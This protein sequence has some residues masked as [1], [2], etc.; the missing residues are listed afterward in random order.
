MLAAIAAAE[1]ALGEPADPIL[2]LSALVMA[3][4]GERD[5]IA[6]RWRLSTAERDGLTVVDRRLAAT[7]AGLDEAG[8][9]RVLYRCGMRRWRQA[10]VALAALEPA[11][12]CE[13]REHLAFAAGWQRPTLPV[14]GADLLAAG[15]P[16]GP[17]VGRLIGELEA[18]WIG[19]DFPNESAVR[20]RLAE[21]LTEMPTRR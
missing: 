15:V 4:E 10:A 18:W 16:P 13:A 12:L 19:N 3:D 11:R 6:A 20:G 9:R 5:R 1:A 14:R 21:L 7:V 17:A 2:R 8:R